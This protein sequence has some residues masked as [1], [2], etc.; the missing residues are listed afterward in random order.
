M[1]DAPDRESQTQDAT[2][3]KLE[4]ARRKGDVAKTPELPAVMS[5]AAA[6]A[7][8]AGSGGMLANNLSQALVPFLAAPQEMTNLLDSGLGAEILRRALMAAAPVVIMVMGA[9][10]LAGAGGHLLQSG[11]L[12][13][14]DKLAPDPGRLSPMA[15]FSRI[16]GPDG[17]VHFLKTLA[18]LIVTG[19]VVWQ[20]VQPHAKEMPALVNMDP[21]EV[22]TFSR[23]LLVA[24]FT[25]VITFLA[26]T[27]GLDWIWQ[28]QRF[29]QR[30]KM[31]RHEIKEEA[32]QSEG[33]PQ[34]K[35][36][37]RQIRMM[38]ARRRMMSQV[39]KA[40][41]IVTNPTHYA[42]ALRYVAGETEAPLCVAKGMD[43]IALKIR[44]IAA[45]HEIPVIEDP[46]LA[47]ALYAAV[48]VEGTIPREHYDAVAKVIGFILGRKNRARARQ[49]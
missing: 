22:L 36:K 2:P 9:A 31:S 29:L 1:S 34:I 25:S 28:R 11:F 6:C 32:R 47:R 18:K 43:Q 46:P 38:R 27:A 37:L 12:W 13:V 4:E 49:L 19:W 7:V 40:T 45:E 41:L 44:E 14:P 17:M 26:L 23:T 33:D 30:M 3:R 42:V 39:P 5:L 48:E 21:R 8:V 16:Y 24:I 10:G 15:S 35:A 20:V